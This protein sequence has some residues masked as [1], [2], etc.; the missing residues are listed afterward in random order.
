MDYHSICR[1][2]KHEGAFP[3][4]YHWIVHVHVGADIHN[5]RSQPLTHI[6]QMERFQKVLIHHKSLSVG[7]LHPEWPTKWTSPTWY[8]VAQCEEAMK[9]SVAPGSKSAIHSFLWMTT[10]ISNAGDSVDK[11]REGS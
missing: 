1:V 2:L 11:N 6:F 10:G 5:T 8:F 4:I 7:N 9:L 3:P